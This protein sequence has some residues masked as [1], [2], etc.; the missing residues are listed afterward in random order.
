MNILLGVVSLLLTFSLLI[1]VEKFF[2]KEGLFV[3]VSIATIIANILVCKS[4][5]IFNITTNLGNILFASS[6]LATDIMSEKYGAKESRK[7]II[8]GV[9]SQVIFVIMTQIGLLYTPAPEDLAQESMK[10]LF[11]INLRVSIASIVMY[12]VSNMADI[13]I[14]EKI[15][16]KVPGKLWLRNNVSTMICNSIENYL[17]SFLAFAGLMDITTILSI[18][19]LASVLEIVIAACD[20]PFLYLSKKLK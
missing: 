9:V 20:T 14:F 11:S 19:T 5:G 2:K 8:L 3:W 12:F 4:I 15:K 18:A 10:G 1:I 7:A 16:E 17:F 6:F 13:Y